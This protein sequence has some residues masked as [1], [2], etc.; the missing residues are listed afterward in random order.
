MPWTIRVEKRAFKDLLKFSKADQKRITDFLDHKLALWEN[1]REFGGALTGPFAG[2]WKYR[3]GDYRAIANIVDA[4]VT[5][6]VVRAGNRREV[7]R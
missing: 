5:I 7:Y 2:L 3:V 6:V 1:P 4:E